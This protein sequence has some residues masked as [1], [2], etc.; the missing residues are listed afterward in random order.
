MSVLTQSFG[1]PRSFS[2]SAIAVRGLLTTTPPM[3]KKAALRLGFGGILLTF[4][5][6]LGGTA[7][8]GVTESSDV[9]K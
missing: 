8:A 7:R 4:E 2:Y 3:S 5:P 9:S 1:I 6:K